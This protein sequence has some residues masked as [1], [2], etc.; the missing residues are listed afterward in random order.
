V[1]TYFNISP[2]SFTVN[3]LSTDEEF[4]S[5][6]TSSSDSRKALL[7]NSALNLSDKWRLTPSFNR[8]LQEGEWVSARTS[9]WYL[10]DCLDL[11][12]SVARTFTRNRDIEPSN[13]YMFQFFLK[14]LSY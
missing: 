13:E 1:F 12:F 7:I 8:D 5:G 10:G 11:Q 6:S 14:N 4:V 3:Y 2:L 9:L